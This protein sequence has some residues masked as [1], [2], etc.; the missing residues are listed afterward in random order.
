[1]SSTSTPQTR[2]RLQ[3]VRDQCKDQLVLPTTAPSWPQIM[4]ALSSPITLGSFFSLEARVPPMEAAPTPVRSRQLP[5]LEELRTKKL[6][7]LRALFLLLG[8]KEECE[9]LEDQAAD[10]DRDVIILLAEEIDKLRQKTS[11][12]VSSRRCGWQRRRPPRA[13]LPRP[14]WTA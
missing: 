4:P 1:M 13:S 6:S 14:R 12:P 8:K 9:A 2:R 10:E 5:P 7:D 11:Q 3:M